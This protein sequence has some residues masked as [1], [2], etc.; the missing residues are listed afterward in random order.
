MR[1]I[2]RVERTSS[3]LF[4]FFF[5]SFFSSLLI[6]PSPWTTASI[7]SSY[8]LSIPPLLLLLPLPLPL[9]SATIITQH[10]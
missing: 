9:P 2:Q 5:F 1:R 4:F 10:L 8:I 6:S 3:F 7:T